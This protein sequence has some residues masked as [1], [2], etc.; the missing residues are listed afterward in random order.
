M[1]TKI[2]HHT[3]RLL[4][5]TGLLLFTLG[6]ERELDELEVATPPV[7]GEVFGDTFSAGLEFAAFGGSDVRAFQVDE[8]VAFEGTASMRFEVPDFEDP[9][10][11]FVGGAFFTNGPRDLSSFNVLTCLAKASKAATIGEI[12]FGNDFGDNI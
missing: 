4:C 10:G 3:F 7:N 2:Y 1:T 9:A 5:L 12:G 6:C 11:A 8:E